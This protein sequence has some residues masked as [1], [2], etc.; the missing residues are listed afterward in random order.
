MTHPTKNTPPSPETAE[1]IRRKKAQYCRFTDTANWAQLEQ[2]FLPNASFAFYN[3]DG[4]IMQS[5]D[6]TLSSFSSRE[7]FMAYTLE[8]WRTIQAIHVLGPGELTHISADEISAI[9]SSITHIGPKEA[10]TG[11]HV[12]GGA[13]YEEIWSFQDG[14]WYIKR[15]TATLVYRQSEEA[16]KPASKA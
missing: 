14:D 12:V 8:R 3:K 16:P 15:M 4:S 9:W 13:Y 10:G 6:G 5:T 2:L 7:E 11:G 1:I